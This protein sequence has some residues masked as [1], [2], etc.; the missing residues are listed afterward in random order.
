MCVYVC[1]C[2]C[3]CVVDRRLGEATVR[4]CSAFLKG[5]YSNRGGIRSPRVKILFF[6]NRPFS[7]VL[8]CRKAKGMS[9][10]L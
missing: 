3:E 9:Q 7:K 10:K 2:V 6:K 8:V 4:M 5:V 1:V